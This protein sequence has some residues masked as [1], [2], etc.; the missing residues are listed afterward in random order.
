MGGNHLTEASQDPS[1]LSCNTSSSS[2]P[3]LPYH[4]LNFPRRLTTSNSKTLI[5]I[6]EVK[7]FHLNAKKVALKESG[8]QRRGKKPRQNSGVSVPQ[9][10]RGPPPSGATLRY[11]PWLRGLG[12]GRRGGGDSLS[13]ASQGRRGGRG[14]AGWGREGRDGGGRGG[15]LAAVGLCVESGPGQLF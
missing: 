1:G 4:R 7:L 13:P 11:P 6:E 8:K 5:F 9:S 15:A 12:R 14:K 2:S 3:T 10:G